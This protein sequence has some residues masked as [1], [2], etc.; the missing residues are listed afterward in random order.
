MRIVYCVLICL[1]HACPYGLVS[2]MKRNSSSQMWVVDLWL[3]F[4]TCK[5]NSFKLSIWAS[6]FHKTGSCKFG[7][8]N[9]VLLCL[10]P[11]RVYQ[12]FFFPCTIIIILIILLEFFLIVFQFSQAYDAW[13]VACILLALLEFIY[14]FFSSSICYSAWLIPNC[15]PIFPSILADRWHVFYCTT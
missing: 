8:V 3:V 1:G 14:D 6:S 5:V 7:L 2:L 9:L 15:F 13:Q 4:G 11:I 10:C 12:V